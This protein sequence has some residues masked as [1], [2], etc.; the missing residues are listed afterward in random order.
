[1]WRLA[2]ASS[3]GHKKKIGTKP[4]NPTNAIQTQHVD[5]LPDS[6]ML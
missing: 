4:A 2:L 1:M 6:A 3:H 5:I